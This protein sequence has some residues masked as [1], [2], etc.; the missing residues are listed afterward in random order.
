VSTDPGLEAVLELRGHARA[1]LLARRFEDRRASLSASYIAHTPDYTI[2]DAQELT[3]ALSSGRVAYDAFQDDVIEYAKPHGPD[4]VVL[5][6]VETVV[7]S[8]GRPNAGKRVARKFSDI[9]RKVGGVWRH[10]VRHAHIADR[11]LARGIV[12]PAAP[13]LRISDDPHVAKVLAYRKATL[14]AITP[15]A[16]RDP[17]GRYSSTFIANTPTGAIVTGPQM[18]TMFAG[19]SV[20]YSSVTQAI[21][22]ANHHAPDLV[23]VMGG[24]IVV[25]REGTPNAGRKIYRRFTDL[26]RL[27]DGEWRHDLR[28]A[29]IWKIE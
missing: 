5:L 25:P 4:L 26:F 22:Y 13:R 17:T 16:S 14:D 8:A 1:A 15:G 11:E 29:N 19:G 18:A 9:Y 23:V 28:H 12:P 27:E 20:G 7:P 2:V 10:D 6:G 3:D 21:E 24:E